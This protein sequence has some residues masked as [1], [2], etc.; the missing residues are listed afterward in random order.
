MFLGVSKAP[1]P[2]LILKQPARGELGSDDAAA[3]AAD[4]R[5]GDRTTIRSRR[6]HDQITIRQRDGPAEPLVGGPRAQAIRDP[7]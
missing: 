6:T 5:G 7:G 1:D 4:H 2:L 3:P